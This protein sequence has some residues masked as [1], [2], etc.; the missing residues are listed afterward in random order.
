[1][2]AFSLAGRTAL[3]T[4]GAAGIGLEITRQLMCE[5]F[6]QVVVVGR[7][8]AKLQAVAQEFPGHI[9][10]AQCDLSDMAQVHAL[11]AHIPEIAPNLSLLVNNAGSQ[12][13]TDFTG[14]DNARFLPSICAEIEANFGSVIALCAGL[15]PLL[16]RQEQ[17]TIVN[18]TSGLALAPKRASPVYC[19]TKAGLRSF[20]MAL[21]YQCERDLRNVRVIEAL[22][23]MV[24]TKMTQGRGSGKIS[25]AICAQQIV[26]GIKAGKS[27]IY[28]GK[29]AV[30]RAI[31]RVTPALGYRMMR[32]G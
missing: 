8:M 7:D 9:T 31:M 15:L 19:A 17:A 25:A 29:T 24:D 2:G 30:F 23:P 3:V 27:E 11:L 12:Q 28:V 1:M 32:D 14:P 10:I 6:A 20:T 13:I 18:V 5:Q 16:A 21:R 26:A 4:G 22:P